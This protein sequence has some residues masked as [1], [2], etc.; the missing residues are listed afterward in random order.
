VLLKTFGE[1]KAPREVKSEVR[2]IDVWFAP[3]QTTADA[4]PLGLL[5]RFADGA[6]KGLGCR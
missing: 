1:V 4:I 2:Q 3:T 5:G 6:T